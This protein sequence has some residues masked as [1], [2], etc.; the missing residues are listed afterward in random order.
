MAHAP[1]EAEFLPDAEASLLCMKKSGSE[2]AVARSPSPFASRPAIVRT[3]QAQVEAKYT[4]QLL[5]EERADRRWRPAAMAVS[6]ALR[7]VRQQLAEEA[8]LR[9]R[10]AS[11]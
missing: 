4:S 9:K 10:D 11:P 1:Q 3:A 8:M 5:E 2:E 7:R 6:M